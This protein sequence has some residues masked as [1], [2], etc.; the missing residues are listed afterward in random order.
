MKKWPLEFNIPMQRAARQLT[1]KPIFKSAVMSAAEYQTFL[2]LAIE[3]QSTLTE[4]DWKPRDLW[5][6]QGFLWVVFN[7]ETATPPTP[8]PDLVAAAIPL[9][10]HPEANPVNHPLN[11]ILYGPPGT[12]K[13]WTTARLAVEICEGRRRSDSADGRPE[14][15]ETYKK[16]VEARRVVF[17][18]FHQSIGY[19]EFVEGLRPVTVGAGFGLIP[20][21]GIFL[22][23]CER[24]ISQP[25]DRFVLIIDEINRANVSKVLGELITLLEPDKRLKAANELIVMLPYSQKRFG[26]PG[27]LHVIGTMNTA[28]RSIALLDTALRR[29]FDFQPMMPDYRLLKAVDDIDLGTLLEKINGRVEVLLDRDHQIGHSYFID[30]KSKA[31]LD[32]VMRRKVIPLLEEYFHGDYEKVLLALNQK[33]KSASFIDKKD[34]P[35]LPGMDNEKRSSYAIADKFTPEGYVAAST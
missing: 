3:V 14:L 7:E 26:V 20:C 34:L 21:P 13:T 8:K 9:S 30:V 33:D 16:L 15:M 17:T 12:G 2:D 32:D 11:L 10:E 29:R 35:V 31:G 1:G 25:D 18:T 6:V 4:W 23:I 5:D 24:A 19:E 28:D 27:N 22:N